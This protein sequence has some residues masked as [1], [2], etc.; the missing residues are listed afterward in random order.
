MHRR[1]PEFRAALLRPREKLEAGVFVVRG[2]APRQALFRRWLEREGLAPLPLRPPEP[3]EPLAPL[4]HLLE[5]HG[6]SLPELEPEELCFESLWLGADTVRMR[7]FLRAALLLGRSPTVAGIRLADFGA[8]VWGAML[9]YVRQ[10]HLH[11]PIAFLAEASSKERVPPNVVKLDL[12]EVDEAEL[13][14]AARPEPASE[15]DASRPGPR[16]SFHALA[17]L[18][19][20]RFF[21][22]TIRPAELRAVT[23]ADPKRRLAELRAA[24]L[25]DRRNRLVP[26]RLH[27]LELPELPQGPRWAERALGALRR[28][29]QAGASRRLWLQ[30]RLGMAAPRRMKVSAALACRAAIE[31]GERVASGLLGSLPDGTL[32]KEALAVSTLFSTQVGE[33]DAGEAM[34]RFHAAL[35]RLGQPYG[36]LLVARLAMRRGEREAGRQLAACRDKLLAAGHQEPAALLSLELARWHLSHYRIRPALQALAS[37]GEPGHWVLSWLKHC[38]LAEVYIRM[39]RLD[40][41]RT[42][43]QKALAA[44]PRPMSPVLKSDFHVTM[45]QLFARAG[46]ELQAE[47]ALEKARETYVAARDAVRMGRYLIVRGELF[48]RAKDREMAKQSFSRAV[49]ILNELKAGMLAREAELKLA[50]LMQGV[51]AET[52]GV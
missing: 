2:M 18:A 9:N 21:G 41:A 42:Y 15:T 33:A 23:R 32:D 27:D 48:W 16:V 14:E 28:R 20:A 43:A 40:F 13:H 22:D 38:V 24:G 6:L 7:L 11:M 37:A 30:A 31:L 34:E 17:Y 52:V 49:R 35:R 8:P 45:G 47:S 4:R 36:P 51:T 3:W 19:Q 1:L 10:G 12:D 29:R 46:W 39:D 25:V 50:L 44:P 26:E 5:H